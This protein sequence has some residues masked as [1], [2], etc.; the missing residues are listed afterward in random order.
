MPQG[1]VTHRNA[2]QSGQSLGAEIV[3]ANLFA[4]DLKRPRRIDRYID[5]FG[6][7]GARRTEATADPC[8]ESVLDAAVT[9]RV[10]NSPV[11][12]WL[13]AGEGLH[14]DHHARPRAP[15][16]SVR[17]SSVIRRGCWFAR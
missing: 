5:Y 6:S 10:H 1:P 3:R 14:N 13:T 2:E 11:L 16:F 12:A 4:V 9:D 7:G 8:G 17:L 15:K